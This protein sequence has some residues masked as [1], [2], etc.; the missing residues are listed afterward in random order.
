MA[1]RSRTGGGRGRG[2]A[3]GA[4]SVQADLRARLG[5]VAVLAAVGTFVTAFALSVGTTGTAYVWHLNMLSDLGDRSCH[6]R[7]ARW[8]CSP[9]HVLF[10]TGLVLTGGLLALAGGLLLRLWGWVLALGVVVMGVGLVV[11]GLFTA[12]EYVVTHMVGVVLA[13]VA[14]GLALLWSAVRPETAWLDSSRVVRGLLAG[15]ALVLAA[16]SRLPDPV[17]PRGA[18]ELAMVLCL[19]AALVV[20]AVRLRPGGREGRPQGPT[21]RSAD[22]TAATASAS[23]TTAPRSGASARR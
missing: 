4:S 11:A 6:V 16:E 20:E 8:I 22:G 7:D 18:G 23:R 12:T 9:A 2:A 15:V 10:N 13:L 1:P 17:I 19:V 14:P 3:P 21:S 5:A